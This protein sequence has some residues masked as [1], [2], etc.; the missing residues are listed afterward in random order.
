MRKFLR[1][2]FLILAVGFVV[3]QFYR[4][5]RTNPPVVPQRS[6]E[7]HF[8]VPPNVSATLRRSCFDCH[9]NETHWP[10]YTNI[11]PVSWILASHINGGRSHLNFDEWDRFNG[12]HE[13]AVGFRLICREI[14]AHNMPLPSY[15]WIHWSSRLSDSDISELCAW[16]TAMQQSLGEPDATPAK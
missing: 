12:S 14:K 10:W 13:Q 9:S 7:S 4:P 8:A 16:T 5:D 15:L 3:I 2:G 1:R 11:S 6:L